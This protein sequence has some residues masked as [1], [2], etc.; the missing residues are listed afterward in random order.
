MLELV[1]EVD[2][3]VEEFNLMPFYKVRLV[4]ISGKIRSYCFR[5]SLWRRLNLPC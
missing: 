1:S 5:M 2:E 4:A 3:V